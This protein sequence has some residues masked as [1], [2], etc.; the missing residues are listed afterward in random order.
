MVFAGRVAGANSVVANLRTLTE[1]H[2]TIRVPLAFGV[3]V[4]LDASAVVDVGEPFAAEFAVQ[5]GVVPEALGGASAICHESTA[6]AVGAADIVVIPD[7]VD[8]SGALSLCPFT[9]LAVGDALATFPVAL[10][11][12]GAE[13]FLGGIGSEGD[14]ATFFALLVGTVPETIVGIS[15]TAV[16]SCG[17]TVTS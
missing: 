14:F 12:F 10:V 5:C 17:A 16:V 8:I 7:A 1:A 11:A 9:V 2:L 3:V 15:E 13:I 4:G 6:R